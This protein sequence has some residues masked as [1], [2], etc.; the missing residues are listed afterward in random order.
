M[1]YSW[2]RDL[3]SLAHSTDT[4]G[5]NN[6]SGLFVLELGTWHT[7]FDEVRRE[8]FFVCKEVNPDTAHNYQRAECMTLHS[9]CAHRIDLIF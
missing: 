7:S 8:W 2:T 9:T 3:H 1:M 5:S 6:V 4:L